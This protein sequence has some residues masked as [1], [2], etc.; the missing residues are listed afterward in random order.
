MEMKLRDRLPSGRAVV[1]AEVERIRSRAEMLGKVLLSPI[2]PYQQTSL[3]DRRQVPETCHR[4]ARD[5]QS[6]TRGDRK[7]VGDDGKEIVKGGNPGLVHL[8]E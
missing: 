2:N 5:D 8:S 7:H 6:M 1:E 3:L 4:P